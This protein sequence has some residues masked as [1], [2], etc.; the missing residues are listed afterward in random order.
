MACD[1]VA[2]TLP[3]SAS[4]GIGPGVQAGFVRGFTLRWSLHGNTVRL[5]TGARLKSLIPTEPKASEE[6][7]KER[8]GLFWSA[9]PGRAFTALRLFR[10]TLEATLTANGIACE[11]AGSTEETVA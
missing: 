1:A 2:R 8:Y 10:I 4:E 11:F 5:V 6:S 9:L 7:T 3:I